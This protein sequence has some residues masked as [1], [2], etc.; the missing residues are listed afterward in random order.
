M[1]RSRVASLALVALLVWVTGCTTYTKIEPGEVAG[2]GTVRVYTAGGKEMLYGPMLE[3]DSIK[4]RTASGRPVAIPVDEVHGLEYEGKG[5]N[6]LA[7]L[8]IIAG[9]LF[10]VGGLTCEPG[11]FGCRD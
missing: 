4:G 8:G 3:A 2:H 6:T 5:V 11:T 1:I 7:T 10:V 9:V